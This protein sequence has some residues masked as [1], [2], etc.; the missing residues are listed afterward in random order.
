[1]D[2]TPD[3]HNYMI[4][5][6]ST[7]IPKYTPAYSR[8]ELEIKIINVI[9]KEIFNEEKSLEAVRTVNEK[10]NWS[11]LCEPYWYECETDM[12]SLKMREN[13]VEMVNF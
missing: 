12:N 4:C 9:A 11:A 6:C 7:N 2:M 13:C 3:W 8:C 1:M 5:I 10:G